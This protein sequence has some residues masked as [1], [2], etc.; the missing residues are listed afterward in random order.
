MLSNIADL[1]LI[2]GIG[3]LLWHTWRHGRRVP[4]PGR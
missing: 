3:L 4:T 2:I 1:F